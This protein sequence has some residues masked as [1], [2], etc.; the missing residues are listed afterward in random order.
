MRIIGLLQ[1]LYHHIS[2][3]TTYHHTRLHIWQCRV[4]NGGTAPQKPFLNWLLCFF[5]SYF[6][7][8]VYFLLSQL[9]FLSIRRTYSRALSGRDCYWSCMATKPK[10]T[11]CFCSAVVILKPRRSR[12]S[13]GAAASIKTWVDGRAKDPPRWPRPRYQKQ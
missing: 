9:C 7:K 3:Y 13:L 12:R 6:Q 1:C 10:G 4:Y 5:F 11:K 8:N 2:P